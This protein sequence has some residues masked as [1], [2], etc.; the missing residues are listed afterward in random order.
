MKIFID[1]ENLDEIRKAAEWGIIDGV[2][3]NPTLIAKENSSFEDIA[4]E[5]IRMVDGPIS[6]EAISMN[7]E[8][9]VKEA[10]EMSEWS[11]NIVVKIPMIPEGLKAVRIL[12]D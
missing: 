1:T 3:T 9:M 10:V 2:T 5:I 7:A 11:Q 12:N 6:V 8:G 4:K